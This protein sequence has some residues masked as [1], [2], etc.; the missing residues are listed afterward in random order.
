MKR[1]I[2]KLGENIPVV[3]IVL[4][5]IHGKRKK[6]DVCFVTVISK[7]RIFLTVSKQLLTTFI[8]HLS[9][10]PADGDVI[11]THIWPPDCKQ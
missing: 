2:Q 10:S 9:F 3:L 5:L 7:Y 4:E 11:F 8:L 6:I 1:S